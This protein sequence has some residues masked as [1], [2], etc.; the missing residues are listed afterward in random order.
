[1]DKPLKVS[2]NPDVMCWINIGGQRIKKPIAAG[3]LNNKD[4]MN[5]YKVQIAN[6]APEI[7]EFVPKRERKP[8]T[9]INVIPDDADFPEIEKATAGPIKAETDQKTTKKRSTK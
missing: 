9:N 7:I 8:V 1:M 5:E 4:F 3:L 6:E 2:K